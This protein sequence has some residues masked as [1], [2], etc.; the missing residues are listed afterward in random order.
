MRWGIQEKA[1]DEHSTTD[2]CLYELDQCCRFSLATNC[3][4]SVFISE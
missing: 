4:V 2:M 1:A 3:V